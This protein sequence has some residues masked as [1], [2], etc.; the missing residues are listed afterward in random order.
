MFRIRRGDVPADPRESVL[1]S[2]APEGLP[3]TPVLGPALARGFLVAG[4]VGFASMAVG[5]V[6]GG[7]YGALYAAFLCPLLTLPAGGIAFVWEALRRDA[8]KRS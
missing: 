4:A 5:G 7:P 3:E 6:L 8:G 2:G 1:A